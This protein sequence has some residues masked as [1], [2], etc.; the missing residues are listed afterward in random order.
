MRERFRAR[1]QGNRARPQRVVA[2]AYPAVCC[3]SPRTRRGRCEVQR[4]YDRVSFAAVGRFNEFD[5]LRRGGIQY[6]DT[7]HPPA[8][9]PRR[10]RPAA[11]QRL[12]PDPGHHLHRAGQALRGRT[13]RRRGG[14]LRRDQA[15]R[16]V[17]HHL[18]R[19]HRRRAALRRDGRHHRADH[20]RA[21]GVLFGRTPNWPTPCG[22]PSRRCAP[23]SP[24]PPAAPH[25]PRPQVLE[26]R[27]PWR[28]RCSTPTGCGGRSAGSPAPRWRICCPNQNQ[29]KCSRGTGRRKLTG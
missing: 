16:A 23:G 3:S 7:R 13:L 15:A 21:Q 28:S 5:S 14:A 9:R 19:L 4:I 12:R 20:Q 10:R 1:P 6:A 11:G 24:V 22:S 25:W 17:P 27:R 29:P 18:R 26:G 2:L 8:D